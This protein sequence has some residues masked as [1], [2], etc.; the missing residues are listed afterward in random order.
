VLVPDLSFPLSIS[1]T[2]TSHC[3]VKN[4]LHIP[5]PKA[6]VFPCPPNF[7]QTL[8]LDR[9]F[10][11][12]ICLSYSPKLVIRKT[13]QC[14]DCRPPSV[15]S[16]SGISDGFYYVSPPLTC[17]PPDWFS[18]VRTALKNLTSSSNL[19]G[20]LSSWFFVNGPPYSPL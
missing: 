13:E 10:Q 18:P 9:K 3:S 2:S 16:K 11:L 17:R 1:N 7:F 8:P 5:L 14:T 19:F 4:F 15:F 12:P 6:K 20:T